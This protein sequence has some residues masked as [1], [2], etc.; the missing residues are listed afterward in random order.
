MNKLISTLCFRGSLRENGNG[1]KEFYGFGSVREWESD[2]GLR[3][4]WTRIEKGGLKM[5]TH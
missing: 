4:L 2:L 5:E 3:F 1:F